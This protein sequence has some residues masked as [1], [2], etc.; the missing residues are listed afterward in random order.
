MSVEVRRL[1]ISSGSLTD[2][3]LPPNVVRGQDWASELSKIMR[4]P[5]FEE[6]STLP[7]LDDL[8]DKLPPDL[9]EKLQKG[10]QELD[11][12]WQAVNDTI[13][14]QLK[15]DQLTEKLATMNADVEVSSKYI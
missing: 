4:G 7:S 11:A 3:I 6:L 9:V 2:A 8:K 12:D 1:Y 15:I 10:A 14:Q 13:R 5:T